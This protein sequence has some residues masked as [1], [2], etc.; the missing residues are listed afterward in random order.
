MTSRISCN[1]PLLLFNYSV[2]SDSLWPHGL[3]HAR[4]PCPSLSPGVCS[5]SCPLSWCYPTISSFV[6]SSFSSPVFPSTRDFSNESVL[7]NRPLGSCE[8]CEL[9]MLGTGE[10][11]WKD[12]RNWRYLVVFQLDGC[13]KMVHGQ[14]ICPSGALDC[15]ILDRWQKFSSG[16]RGSCNTWHYSNTGYCS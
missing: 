11:C 5:N 15:D 8:L 14:A 13:F 12:K 9:F 6:A 1:R 16:T 3:Q 7:C 2:V 10:V 4:L